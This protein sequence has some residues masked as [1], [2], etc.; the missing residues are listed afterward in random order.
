MPIEI[1]RKLGWGDLRVG[2]R[3]DN[4]I[5]LPLVPEPEDY[6]A[7]IVRID[8]NG[9]PISQID[10][11]TVPGFEKSEIL[12]FAPAPNG[13]TYVL[14]SPVIWER[15]DRK[16]DGTVGQRSYQL[17]GAWLLKFDG[18]GQFISKAPLS[19]SFTSP[20]L[21]VYTS[22]D[23]FLVGLGPGQKPGPNLVAG[24]FSSAGT[25]VSPVSLPD[26]LTH[27][28]AKG[29]LPHLVPVSGQDGNVYVI[30]SLDSI[31]PGE[32][33]AAAT[34]SPDGKVLRTIV[35][36]GQPAQTGMVMP[37]MVNDRFWFALWQMT[38]EVHATHFGEFDSMGALVAVHSTEQRSARP[39]CFTPL[40]F[41]VLN[42]PSATLDVFEVN[43]H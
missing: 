6:A 1:A 20:K 7:L 32:F 8:Q 35:F 39:V 9:A 12:D 40:G 15:V 36:H 22:G 38:K 29:S 28:P 18:D 33:A 16:E 23:L 34:I 13:I 37:R 5:L 10:I 2:C 27:D 25:L 17:G 4:T 42:G 21:A 19:P 26:A 11:S 24:I 3:N 41:E 31:Y 30:R 14:S 43:A